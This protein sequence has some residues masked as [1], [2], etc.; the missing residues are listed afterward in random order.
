MLKP[1]KQ[2]PY[3]MIIKRF[4]FNLDAIK[5]IKSYLCVIKPNR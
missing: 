4:R 2:Y 3:K 1:P 5:Q